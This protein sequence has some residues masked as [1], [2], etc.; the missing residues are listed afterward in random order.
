MLLI[1]YILI[2]TDLNN[3]SKNF[4]TKNLY[5]VTAASDEQFAT[6]AR[7]AENT[8]GL[9]VWFELELVCGMEMCDYL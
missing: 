5:G 2:R 4:V 1:Y 6:P 9:R 7:R 8:F 3:A